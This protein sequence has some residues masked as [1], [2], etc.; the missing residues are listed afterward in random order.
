MQDPEQQIETVYRQSAPRIRAALIRLLGSFDLA[1]EAL[2]DAFLEASRD[3]PVD[4]GPSTG[5]A[6]ALCSTVTRTT[7]PISPISRSRRR[8]SP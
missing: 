5:C 4:S 1:E 3:W 2:H 6:N 7:S 8:M